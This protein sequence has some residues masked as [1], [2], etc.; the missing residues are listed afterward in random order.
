MFDIANLNGDVAAN[1]KGGETD[2]IVPQVPFIS[3][4]R[5]NGADNL[6]NGFS[7]AINS[8]YY[9]DKNGVLKQG[10]KLEESYFTSQDGLIKVAAAESQIIT[11]DGG[12]AKRVVMTL[13]SKGRKNK[14][15]LE[16]YVPPVGGEERNAVI[17]YQYDQSVTLSG[18]IYPN[19]YGQGETL[20]NKDVIANKMI[21]SG[22][23]YSSNSLFDI[24]SGE[25]RYNKTI[26]IDPVT[27]NKVESVKVVLYTDKKYVTYGPDNKTGTAYSKEVVRETTVTEK[28]KDKAGKPT[29]TNDTYRYLNNNLAQFISLENKKQTNN[30]LFDEKGNISI[31]DL[32]Y[33]K[34]N[35]EKG[36]NNK[37]VYDW[38]TGELISTVDSYY[39][40][41]NLLI[42]G[43]AVLPY[44]NE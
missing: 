34:D 44:P 16:G 9:K 24:Y 6:G 28:G 40:Q 15:E 41:R 20:E 17:E 12:N 11:S 39:M 25:E 27:E 5:F 43:T 32:N 13:D 31:T 21:V 4:E 10:G 2:A 23:D 30:L 36:Y 8:S 7:Y 33:K 3:S 29:V 14:E 18:T 26:S 38:F 35:D 22:G 19:G 1:L 37:C 42:D